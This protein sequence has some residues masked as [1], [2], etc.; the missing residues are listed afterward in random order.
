MNWPRRH[1]SH[2]PQLPP[3]QP[4]PTRWPSSQPLTPSP[5][6]AIPARTL[7]A[8]VVQDADRIDGLGAIGISRCL[9]VG[10]VLQR[11]LYSADDPFCDEREP[12]DQAFC[13][14]HFYRKLFRVAETLHTA[15]ARSE[16]AERV[17]FM[18]TYLA[19]LGREM[20]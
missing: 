1:G 16:A 18:R 8:Q 11:P 10:G 17:A 4:T 14:D 12:D 3:N 5:S 2:Q 13:V 7:E 6:A 19:Q 20:R 9:L 15:A